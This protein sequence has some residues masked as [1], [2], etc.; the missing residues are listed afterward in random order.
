MAGAVAAVLVVGG[1]L[2]VS[3]AVDSAE[4][5]RIAARPMATAAPVSSSVAPASSAA[6][7]STAA[8]APVP[9]THHDV[10]YAIYG[11]SAGSVSW[12]TPGYGISQDVNVSLPW[13][14]YE[15]FNLGFFVATVNAQDGGTGESIGCEI[16]VDGVVVSSHASH[17]QFAF[18][19]CTASG[20]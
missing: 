16:S 12:S 19:Q 4:R 5:A 14:M 3:T 13:S 10:E 15:S 9:R 2:Y 8:P 7:L 17:G 20:S 18:V 11:S 6:A 1:A